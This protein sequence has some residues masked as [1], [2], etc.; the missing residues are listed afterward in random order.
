MLDVFK[1]FELIKFRDA[2]PSRNSVDDTENVFGESFMVAFSQSSRW[3]LLPLLLL[4]LF[5]TLAAAFAAV[6]TPATP[7]IVIIPPANPL[8]LLF[9]VL[10]QLLFSQSSNDLLNWLL[11]IVAFKF[12]LWWP[13]APPLA[14][15]I[16]LFAFKFNDDADADVDTFDFWRDCFWSARA[17]SNQNGRK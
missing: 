13:F 1:P 2:G 14:A 5:V 12:R 6:G 3:L 16:L 4:L 11:L 9:I 10:L 8:W 15:F 7:P 17:H